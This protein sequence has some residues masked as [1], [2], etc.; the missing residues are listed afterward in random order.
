MPTAQGG[1]P[2]HKAREHPAHAEVTRWW[3]TSASRGRSRQ[4]A[5]RTL[6]ETGMAVG[7]PAY[8]SP[9]QASGPAVDART[10]IYALGACSTRCWP[11]SRRLPDRR[12]RQSSPSDSTPMPCRSAPCGLRCPSMWSS[13]W[14]ARSPGCRPT[15]LPPPPNWL[16]RSGQVRRPRLRARASRRVVD[17][18]AAGAFCCSRWACCS[19]LGVLFGWSWGRRRR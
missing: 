17:T 2:R 7:T 5:K 10:D 11:A 14:I 12:R 18:L 19:A 1:P 6:T 13:R 3:P 15:G 4:R 9:E 8:M 16:A